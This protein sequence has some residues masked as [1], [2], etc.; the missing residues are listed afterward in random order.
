MHTTTFRL[1]THDRDPMTFLLLFL[2]LGF[3]FISS[4]KCKF[5]ETDKMRAKNKIEIACLTDGEKYVVDMP[6]EYVCI[7]M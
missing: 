3:L 4:S 2:P 1:L 7:N 5:T 6:F